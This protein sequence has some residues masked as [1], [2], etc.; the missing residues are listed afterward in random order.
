MLEAAA[1]LRFCGMLIALGPPRPITGVRSLDAMFILEFIVECLFFTVCGWIGHTVVK[2]I[3]FGKVDLEWG[4]GSE[5]VLAEWLGL[6]FLLL[7][8]GLI[9]WMMHR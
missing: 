9:A 3:A 7:V 4:S 8:A 2:V 6:F 1:G 5:S